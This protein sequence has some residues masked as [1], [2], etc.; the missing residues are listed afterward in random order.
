VWLRPQPDPPRLHH[1]PRRI[2]G[3]STSLGEM[4]DFSNLAPHVTH[5]ALNRPTPLLNGSTTTMV[6]ISTTMEISTGS[7]TRVRTLNSQLRL[8]PSF[9]P[10]KPDVASLGHPFTRE[11]ITNLTCGY[12]NN[13]LNS[14]NDLRYH[15]S[16]VR[17]HSVFSCCGRFF[18]REV[19]LQRHRDAKYIHSNEVI[20]NG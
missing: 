19:D 16:H 3:F 13:R 7:M 2:P 1:L 14:M 5:L 10:N 15:L 17:Y 12:C 18:R 4:A 11:M 8:R 9:D 6:A 20:R